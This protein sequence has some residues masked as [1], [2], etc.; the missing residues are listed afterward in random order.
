LS[1]RDI[2]LC[3]P[4][5]LQRGEMISNGVQPRWWRWSGLGLSQVLYLLCVVRA[6]LWGSAI[7]AQLRGSEAHIQEIGASGESCTGIEGAFPSNLCGVQALVRRQMF[8][9]T[10]AVIIDQDNPS[11]MR[12]KTALMSTGL[13]STTTA[14]GLVVASRWAASRAKTW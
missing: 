14:E 7:H 9:L 12:A 3:N 13:L 4:G 11:Q 2:L 1:H 5:E 10:D 6:R 8:D